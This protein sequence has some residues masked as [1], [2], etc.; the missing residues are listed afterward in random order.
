LLFC[1]LHFLICILFVEIALM[2]MLLLYLIFIFLVFCLLRNNYVLLHLLNKNNMI[3]GNINIIH[4]KLTINNNF[5]L[6]KL[7]SILRLLIQTICISSFIFFTS[8]SIC[9]TSLTPPPSPVVNLV[10]FIGLHQLMNILLD[11]L[12]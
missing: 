1:Y 5:T 11:D 2:C 8:S 6:A 12:P 9:S 4:T 3:V 7:T 10:L